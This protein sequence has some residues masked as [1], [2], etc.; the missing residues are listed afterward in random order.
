MHRKVTKV[1]AVTPTKKNLCPLGWEKALGTNSA[2]NV[3]LLTKG[4]SGLRPAGSTNTTF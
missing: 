2:Y 4:P 1:S 3:L